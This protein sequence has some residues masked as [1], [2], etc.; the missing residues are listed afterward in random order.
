MI[1]FRRFSATDVRESNSNLQHAE[2]TE[3]PSS[4]VLQEEQSC[5]STSAVPSFDD[6]AQV[7]SPSD[8]Q[9]DSSSMRSPPAPTS[10]SQTPRRSGRIR[11]P[12]KRLDI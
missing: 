8:A 2:T 10:R 12:P 4:Q 11:R 5:S 3:N 1:S 9:P 7:S 6:P